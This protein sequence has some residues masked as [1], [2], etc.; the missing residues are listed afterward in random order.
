M[1]HQ[2]CLGQRSFSLGSLQSTLRE[3]LDL[4]D[5]VYIVI[6]ALDEC[7]EEQWGSISS[8]IRSL[9]GWSVSANTHLLLTGRPETNIR[10]C[11]EQLVPS[12]YVVKLGSE[13][14]MR[15][16]IIRYVRSTIRGDNSDFKR[17]KADILM[18]IENTLVSGANG[19]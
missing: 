11:L 1:L 15:D 9:S 19:M 5:H 10:K 3:M 12:A 16:D 17:W 8:F 6:D 7:A 18:E 13:L 2:R 14:G 4:F